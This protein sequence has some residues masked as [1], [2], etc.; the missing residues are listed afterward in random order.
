[1]HEATDEN[2]LDFT[3]PVFCAGTQIYKEEKDC[4]DR[5]GTYRGI[6]AA[7]CPN[8]LNLALWILYSK[9][10]QFTVLMLTNYHNDHFQ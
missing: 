7:R 6:R 1:M 4:S 8:H 10:F 9:L 2:D 3:I 5:V